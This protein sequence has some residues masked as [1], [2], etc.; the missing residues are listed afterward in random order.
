MSSEFS[1]TLDFE[2]SIIL[3]KIGGSRIIEFKRHTDPVLDN[4]VEMWKYS[5]KKGGRGKSE[6]VLLKDLSVFLES[7]LNS[8]EYEMVN[9]ETN[10]TKNNKKK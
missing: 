7:Y 3:K 8:G 6:W 4:I 9:S 2:S 1:I 5:E 10:R